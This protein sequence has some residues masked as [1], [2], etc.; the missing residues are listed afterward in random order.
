MST[1]DKKEIMQNLG[2]GTVI[3]GLKIGIDYFSGKKVTFWSLNNQF[4]FYFSG[5]KVTFW[6]FG[7]ML[8][9]GAAGDLINDQIKDKSWYPFKP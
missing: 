7:K 2:V 5:K 1:V 8:A 4:Q 6:S 9:I 3:A